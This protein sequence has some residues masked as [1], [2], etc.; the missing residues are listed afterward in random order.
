MILD[1]RQKLFVVLTATFC[2]CLLVGDLIGG[3]L[4]SFSLLG[5]DFTTTV[6]MIPFPVTFLLTDVINEFYGKRAARFVTFVALGTALLAY[7]IVYVAAAVPIA[8]MTKQ[9]DWTGVR[10][11][12]F[13][14]V[15]IG[16]LRMLAASL[17]AFMV[18]QLVDIAVFAALKRW[19]GTRLLWLRATG[20]TA[21]SQ[22][23]DTITITLVAWIGM[24]PLSEILRIIVSAYTMKLF[25]AFGLTPLVYACHRL[26]EGRLGMS[27]ASRDGE[28]PIG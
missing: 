10:D 6:G 15:F 27:P 25:I 26:I 21:I 9:A 17:V 4:I 5:L 16:S 28:M 1:T 23:I 11:A 24:M 3:K 12:S 19:S 18:S 22:L 7:A 13:Q 20:S 8:E 14:N 2:T